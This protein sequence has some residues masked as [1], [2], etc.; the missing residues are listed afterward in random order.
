[1]QD[2]TAAV[3]PDWMALERQ[4]IAT[5]RRVAGKGLVDAQGSPVLVGLALSGGGIRSATLS[6]GMLQALAKANVLDEIDVMSTVSGGGYAGGFLGALYMPEQRR[7]GDPK[8]PS[9]AELL[10]AARAAVQR[11]TA[12]E[13]RGDGGSDAAPI[14]WLRD[15]GRYLA[16]NGGGDAW[17]GFT[18]WLR[19]LLAVHY[20]IGLGLLLALML[21]GWFNDLSW[22]PLHTAL[23]S[24]MPALPAWLMPG[25]LYGLLAL[26]ALATAL[27]PLGIAYWYTEMPKGRGQGVWAGLLTDTALIGMLMGPAWSRR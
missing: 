16:P 5:R 20:V 26:L 11:L 3:P 12:T 13:Q 9:D 10:A 4:R 25:M 7:L 17:R 24:R 27:L 8:A 18:L 6:V 22:P 21:L 23:G 14:S 1:M 19:N 15:C 2:K